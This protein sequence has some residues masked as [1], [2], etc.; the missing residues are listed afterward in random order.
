MD[1]C[2]IYVAGHKGMVGSAL[3]RLL[4]DKHEVKLIVRDRAKLDLTNQI[5]VQ[6][7]FKEEKV[8]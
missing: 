5:E 6:K 4:K 2:R 8:S 3:V 1:N 7:F